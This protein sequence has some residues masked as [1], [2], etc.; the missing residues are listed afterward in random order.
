M[1]LST[2]TNTRSFPERQANYC[3]LPAITSAW[4][5][6]LMVVML[7]VNNS[8]AYLGPRGGW[9]DPLFYTSIAREP[10]FYV[11]HF[12]GQYFTT[13]IP[14]FAIPAIVNHVFD[15][16]VAQL[17]RTAIVVALF[18]LPLSVI[19]THIIRSRFGVMSAILVSLVN[20]ELFLFAGMDYTT[21]YCGLWM[22]CSLACLMMGNGRG[23]LVISGFFAFAAV[24]CHVFAVALL[25]ILAVTYFFLYTHS[26]LPVRNVTIDLMTFL[27]GVIISIAI[28]STSY[29]ALGGTFSDFFVQYIDAYTFRGQASVWHSPWEEWIGA[30]T[31]LFYPAV[32]FC[33]A[34]LVAVSAAIERTI[35]RPI[36][37][38]ACAH[39]LVCLIFIFGQIVG[40]FYLQYDF[41]AIMLVPTSILMQAY[42]IGTVVDMMQSRALRGVLTVSLLA[43]N[44]IPFVLA[45]TTSELPYVKALGLSCTLGCR[46]GS[47]ELVVFAAWSLLAALILLRRSLAF[48]QRIV[49]AVL[50]L[51]VIATNGLMFVRQTDNRNFNYPASDRN[52]IAMTRLYNLHD[53]IES[54][55]PNLNFRMWYKDDNSNLN[56]RYLASTFLYGPQL[57]G[58]AAP[59]FRLDDDL[60]YLVLK[61]GDGVLLIGDSDKMFGESEAAL[62]AV[63]DRLK[64]DDKLFYLIDPGGLYVSYYLVY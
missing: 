44:V 16:R 31:W 48:S 25:P 43:V 54:R 11:S 21:I 12:G 8:F 45:S 51:G 34:L 14:A 49:S 23:L 52:R 19:G 13:R 55:F 10:H 61:P 37:A 35:P 2:Q 64:F 15:F 24:Q 5:L 46:I 42:L 3:L 30:A 39:I 6:F 28:F 60:R 50:V 40:L 41:Y 47:A 26:E 20:P 9:V 63:R 59:V 29:M 18:A 33:I 17:V 32:G 27:L 1:S 57:I 62:E 53:R 4:T 56:A 7:T 22:S 38:L 36:I 58:N